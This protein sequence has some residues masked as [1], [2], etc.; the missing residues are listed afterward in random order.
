MSYRIEFTPAARKTFASLSKKERERLDSRILALRDNPRPFGS[1]KL[2]GKELYRIRAG[3]Y[4][5]IYQIRDEV[6]VVLVVKIGHRREVYSR[7]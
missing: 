6:L 5:V 1:K 7:L 4:R 2:A 3:N